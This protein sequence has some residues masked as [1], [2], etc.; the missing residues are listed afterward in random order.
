[1]INIQDYFATFGT[2]GAGCTGV[3]GG[4]LTPVVTFG[5]GNG[6]DPCIGGNGHCGGVG[7]NGGI[8]AGGIGDLFKWWRGKC[9]DANG[10]ICVGLYGFKYGLL[11][12]LISCSWKYPSLK[13]I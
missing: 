4:A 9:F 10:K 3:A 11:I 8:P 1:M 12:I 5:T 6:A 13:S 7:G 2:G